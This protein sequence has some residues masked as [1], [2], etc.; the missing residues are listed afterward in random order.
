MAGKKQR[1]RINRSIKK[2]VGGMEG[3]SIFTFKIGDET[4]LDKL[5]KKGDRRERVFN[6]YLSKDGKNVII[7][8]F[9][10]PLCLK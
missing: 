8:Y 5:T 6:F 1:K 10:L 3:S 7:F 2:L 9:E 4:K